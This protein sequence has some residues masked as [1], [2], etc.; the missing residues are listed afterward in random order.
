MSYEKQNFTSHQVLTAAALNHMEDGIANAGGASSWNDLKDKP[1]DATTEMVEI[2]PEQSFT[3]TES[4]DEGGSYEGD[5]DVLLGIIPNKKYEIKINGQSYFANAKVEEG[6]YLLYVYTSDDKFIFEYDYTITDKKTYGP[7]MHWALDFGETITLAI[8][9]EQEVVKK[10]DPKFMGSGTCFTYSDND[11]LEYLRHYN[12][13]TKKM[14]EKVTRDELLEAIMRG[15]IW[16]TWHSYETGYDY[17]YPIEG[18]QLLD[19]FGYIRYG[20]KRYYSAEYTQA[21]GPQ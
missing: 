1:F 12:P 18:A 17:F 10:L 3:G 4:M 6:D 11:D 21:S 15:A 14:G 8:Y 20:E 19:E 5:I 7:Y 2:L 13:I 16:F 9:E